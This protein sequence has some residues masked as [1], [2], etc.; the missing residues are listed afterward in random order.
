MAARRMF[1]KEI[2]SSDKFLDMPIS[3][4]ALF[5]HLGVNADDEGFVSSP[6]RIQ[7]G[8]GCSDDDLKLLIG[9]KFLIAFETGVIVIREWDTHNKIRKDRMVP[10]IHQEEKQ[11]LELFVQDALEGNVNQV[12]TKCQ[13][14]VNQVSTSC[15]HSIVEV[16]AVETRIEEDRIKKDSHQ[17]ETCY[18]FD[19]FWSDYDNKTGRKACEIKYAKIK[20][21]DRAII[22]AHLPHYVANTLKTGYPNRKHPHSYLKGENYHDE[23]IPVLGKGNVPTQNDNYSNQ[24]SDTLRF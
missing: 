22:K 9:K 15:P 1:H 10:T 5:F 14:N 17:N 24:Y 18:S 19:Q 2:V 16:S 7:R 4:Q 21:A 11:Q 6:K 8:I 20:E 13:P 12:A 23:P 3:T